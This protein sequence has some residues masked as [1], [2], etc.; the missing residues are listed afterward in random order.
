M[1][2][3]HGSYLADEGRYTDSPDWAEQ[4]AALSEAIGRYRQNEQIA[5]RR[6]RGQGQI[7]APAPEVIE[8]RDEIW[9]EILDDLYPPG[10]MEHEGEFQRLMHEDLA[11]MSDLQLS[12]ESGRARLRAFLDSHPIPWLTERIV[13]LNAEQA[14]RDETIARGRR[15]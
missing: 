7:A 1:N 14:R 8:A 2:Q 12:N 10:G 11:G 15:E 3:A 13:A 5:R 6:E 9:A 4:M